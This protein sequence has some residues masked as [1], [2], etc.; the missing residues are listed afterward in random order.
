MQHYKLHNVP[1]A[2]P[3]E[4]TGGIFQT[5]FTDIIYSTSTSDYLAEA[6]IPDDCWAFDLPLNNE[7]SL[8][9]FFEHPEGNEHSSIMAP[10]DKVKWF[11]NQ[12]TLNCVALFN[13]DMMS[14]HLTENELSALHAITSTKKRKNS[15]KNNFVNIA[16]SIESVVCMA[17]STR[18]SQ[19]ND[20]D[21]TIIELATHITNCNL[22]GFEENRTKTRHRIFKDAIWYITENY[23]LDINVADIARESCTSA[24][25]LQKVFLS[26]IGISPM[27]FLKNYRLGMFK[28]ALQAEGSISESARLAGIKHL[29]RLG[30][31]FKNAYGYL[32][33]EFNQKRITSAYP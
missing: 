24:R 8:K 28:K 7:R 12:N 10:G 31:E 4:M 26:T 30:Q 6:T 2:G 5:P 23:H 17:D 14:K 25:N 9:A 19:S 22:S 16:Q 1:F 27:R 15:D 13:L 18:F 29:G 21:I 3:I 32:P 20:W 11:A 33:S